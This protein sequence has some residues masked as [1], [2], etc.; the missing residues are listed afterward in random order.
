MRENKDSSVYDRLFSPSWSQMCGTVYWQFLIIAYPVNFDIQ[1]VGSLKIKGQE[2]D[3]YKLKWIY[4][5]V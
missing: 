2:G 5:E 1:W 4:I 3:I